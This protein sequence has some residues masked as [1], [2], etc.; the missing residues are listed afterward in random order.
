M[1]THTLPW[2]AI[3]PDARIQGLLRNNIL[4]LSPTSS[5]SGRI[6]PVYSVF[7]SIFNILDD[8]QVEIAHRWFL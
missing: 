1:V 3:F 7:F 6:T 2:A 5:V 4:Q 8:F